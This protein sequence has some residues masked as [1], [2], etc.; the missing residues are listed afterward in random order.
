[1]KLL[2]AFN[3]N[4][5]ANDIFQDEVFSNEYNVRYVSFKELLMKSDI[6]SLHLNLSKE[7]IKLINY[8]SFKIMK[9]NAIIINT[10]RGEI[11][12]EASLIKALDEKLIYG[13]GLD[14]FNNEPYF[15]HL[16]KYDNVILTPHIGSYAKEI[17][18][19]MEVEAVQNIINGLKR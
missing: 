10:S 7:I 12:D 6:I 16:V 1:M 18:I 13:A 4:F 8:D 19:K 5:I 2:N 15:G 14:V 17:R 11:I 3:L 9:R